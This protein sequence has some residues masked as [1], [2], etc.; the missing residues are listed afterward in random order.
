M[1]GWALSHC[2][3]Q[4]R[5]LESPMRITEPWRLRGTTLPLPPVDED[6]HQH[7]QAQEGEC[8]HHSQRDSSSHLLALQ[9]RRRHPGLRAAVAHLYLRKT[10]AAHWHI[11]TVSGTSIFTAF[12]HQGLSRN[13]FKESKIRVGGKLAILLPVYVPGPLLEKWWTST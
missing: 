13:K 6:P 8:S 1:T 11:N 12:A 5:S 2:T 7:Q 10:R 4:E 3:P 9:P